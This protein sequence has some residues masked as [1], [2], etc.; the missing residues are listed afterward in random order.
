MRCVQLS[1]S[2][3]SAPSAPTAGRSRDASRGTTVTATTSEARSATTTVRAK[4][5]KKLPA[6]PVRK[7]IGRKTAT[8]VRVDEETAVMIS[9]AP[10]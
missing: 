7:T 1:C 5:R 9:R 8:V 3:R 2:L 4:G 10:V 6:M